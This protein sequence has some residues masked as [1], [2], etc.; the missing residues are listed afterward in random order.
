MD[1]S[2]TKKPMKVSCIYK[3]TC[4]VNNKIYIGS[5]V[6]YE[7][8]KRHHLQFLRRRIHKNTHLQNAYNLYGQKGFIFEIIEKLNDKKDTLQKEQYWMDKTLCYNRKIGFNI[9]SV[10]GSSLGVKRTDE[11]KE[12]I[13]QI[14]QNRPQAIKDK[15]KAAVLKANLG[16]KAWNKGQRGLFSHSVESKNK[17]SAANKK[18]F[19]PKLSPSHYQS[20]C[21][22]NKLPRGKK[23]LRKVSVR[24]SKTYYFVS[25][26]SNRGLKIFNLKAFCKNRG[27]NEGRMYQVAKGN[28]REYKGWVRN[29]KFYS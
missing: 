14:N 24:S 19:H 25:P 6:D 28:E 15:T 10:A 3:I 29:E 16:K 2:P 22:A 8:R 1:S 21:I 13:R 27:L 17:I 4:T 9:C 5:A 11:F 7:T 18:I 12:K 20:V 23:Y 26:I